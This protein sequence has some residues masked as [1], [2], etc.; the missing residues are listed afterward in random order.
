METQVISITQEH[1]D[2]AISSR[3]WNGTAILLALREQGLDGS[4]GF[5]QS[6]RIEGGIPELLHTNEK[7]PTLEHELPTLGGYVIGQRLLNWM[8]NYYTNY[9]RQNHED[10]KP[11]DF[12]L[13]KDGLN[14]YADI[15]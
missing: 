7:H 11:V 3:N 13:V 14:W 5:R 2:E 1:I 8:E 12:E 15:A 10:I 4:V 6:Y 9:I